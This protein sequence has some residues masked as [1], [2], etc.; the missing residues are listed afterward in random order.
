M[1]KTDIRAEL[2]AIAAGKAT[3]IKPGEALINEA[4]VEKH[5]AD[6]AAWKRFSEP[7]AGEPLAA[8]AE[9]LTPLP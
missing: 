2:E 6:F 1:A 9:L 4:L 3:G 7:R 8:P 5:G